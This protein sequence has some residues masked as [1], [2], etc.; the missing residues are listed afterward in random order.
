MSV[1][2]RRRNARWVVYLVI[3]VLMKF[4]H[5][6]WITHEI[7]NNDF[8]SG[9]VCRFV[10]V[11]IKSAELVN[12]QYV[13]W[14]YNIIVGLIIWDLRA[15]VKPRF[16]SEARVVAGGEKWWTLLFSEVWSIVF[17]D[18]VWS[19]KAKKLL[20]YKMWTLFQIVGEA[21]LKARSPIVRN[22]FEIFCRAASCV[23]RMDAQQC[24]LGLCE[25]AGRRRISSLQ[26][27][28]P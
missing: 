2:F 5:L 11:K 13:M 6:G 17:W 25:D 19:Q 24:V 8:Q 27:D 3:L 9:S 7:D 4:C 15:N 12:F 18:G 28:S 20:W 14:R 10:L 26:T 1:A 23:G 21:E 16:E 22:T